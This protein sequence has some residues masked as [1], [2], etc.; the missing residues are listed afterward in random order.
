MTW[1]FIVRHWKLVLTGLA[2]T[3]LTS[4]AAYY[5]I[6]RDHWRGVAKALRIDLDNVRTATELAD[7]KARTA[8]LA[9]EAEY[10]KK[11]DETDARY[12]AALADAR[13]RNADYARR[14]RIHAP[15]SAGGST[16][17]ADSGGAQGA[18]GSGQEPF[19]AVSQSDFDILTENTERLK[20]AHQW[21][22]GLEGAKCE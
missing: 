4:T 16:T 14:M 2:L 10:R 22:C 17:P 5:R 9:A 7:Q 20:A 3:I 15:G 6:D 18:D 8:K 1:L 11:A 21:A 12:E 19:V 13:A